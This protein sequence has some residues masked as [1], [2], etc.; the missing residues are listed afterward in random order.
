MR[1]DEGLSVEQGRPAKALGTPRT[2][3]TR[4]VRSR[5]L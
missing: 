1:R 4:R 3:R 5:V 2:G